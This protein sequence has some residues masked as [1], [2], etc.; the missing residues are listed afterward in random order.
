M[1]IACSNCS[2]RLQLDDAK[3]PSRPFTVRCPKCEH[4]INAQPAPPPDEGSAVAAGGDLPSTTRTQRDANPVSAAVVNL[5][6]EDVPVPSLSAPASP[7]AGDASPLAGAAEVMRML[8]EVL[9][10]GGGVGGGGAGP[11]G[12]SHPMRRP[13]WHKRRALICVST[14][15]KQDIARDLA[16]ENYEVSL[17][18][19]AAQATERMR[20]EELDVLVLDSEFDM[21]G[22][23]AAF[24]TREINSL[25]LAERRRLVLVHLSTSART[26]DAHAAFLANANLVVNTTEVGQLPRALERTFRD[27]NEL[28]KEFNKALGVAEL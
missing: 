9:G 28:Y 27:L 3:V 25:R 12:A 15:H 5:P 6:A 7:P 26:E 13:A 16:R 2:T 18:D 21:A 10:G 4:I 19:N 11:H 14:S 22:Q 8:A 24:I 23:G 17:A 1:I 20:E